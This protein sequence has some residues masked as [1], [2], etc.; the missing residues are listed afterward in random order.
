M[1]KL[2]VIGIGP[3]EAEG[4]T[5]EAR[6]ALV[7]SD[8]IVG[9]E[10]YTDLI[11]DIYPEKEYVESGMRKEVERCREALRIADEGHVV[12]VISSGDP[13]VYGMA[14]LVAELSEEF[15][16]VSV[17][18][19]SGV[20]ACLSGAARLGAPIGHDFCVISL[21][22]ALTPWEVIEKRL[23]AAAEGDFCI[24]I[25]NPESKT[26][27]GYLARACESLLSIKSK[28]T[29]CGYVRNIGRDGEE[30][31]VL[32]LGELQSTHVDMFTTV[33]VGNSMTKR[34]GERMVTPRGYQ[35]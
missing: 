1:K 14:S 4:L 8:V 16:E 31:C 9:Y 20:S 28:D 22:D 26:R 3:G 30:T 35:S 15:P 18:M 25:Y 5:G 13:G 29:V 19:V 34:I 32:T 12:S 33:F 2:Y 10:V 6:T 17:T 27:S 21:S 7:V 24:C 11:R 23:R